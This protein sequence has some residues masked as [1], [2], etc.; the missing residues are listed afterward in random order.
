MDDVI[1]A[2]RRGEPEAVRVLY[3]RHAGA[4]H[5][6]ARSIVGDDAE[7]CADVVQ[8]TFLKAWR[9]ADRFDGQRDLAPWLYTIARRSAID[10]IRRERH[11]TR[12]GH[13]PEVEAAVDPPSL[14]RTWE[15]HQL[16]LA[17]DE[18]PEEE[19]EVVRLSHL[20]G[21]THAEIADRLDIP[22]GTVKSRSH[23]AMRRL[24]H[25]LAHLMQ[26]TPNQ[27]APAVVEGREGR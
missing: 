5:T 13:L 8:Q 26:P 20:E 4:V 6:V 22:I 10:A 18:L 25:A 21:L 16:R 27:P 2:F 24:G 23:R 9:A 19:R 14:A 3:R 7:L 12:G 15:V 17:L 11:P 1:E